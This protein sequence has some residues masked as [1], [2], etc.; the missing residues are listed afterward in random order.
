[1]LLPMQT[2][3]P[4]FQAHCFL[5]PK[6]PD[7]FWHCFLLFFMII[8]IH[9]FC[10]DSPTPLLPSLQDPR[11]KDKYRHTHTHTQMYILCPYIE[12]GRRQWILMSWLDSASCFANSQTASYEFMSYKNSCWAAAPHTH[13]RRKWNKGQGGRRK[14]MGTE[15]GGATKVPQFLITFVIVFMLFA[16]LLILCCFIF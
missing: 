5:L 8:C 3:W 4:H 11:R 15:V 7:A 6:T 1:M 2:V 10:I 16:Y 14:G 9:Q 12:I 13:S